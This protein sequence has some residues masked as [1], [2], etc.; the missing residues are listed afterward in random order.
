MNWSPISVKGFI[1]I[2]TFIVKLKNY[3]IVK[4]ELTW[5]IHE[6]RSLQRRGSGPRSCSE[7]PRV[8]YNE[9]FVVRSA[10]PEGKNV[11]YKNKGYEN[12]VVRLV[13]RKN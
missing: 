6:L 8:G 13:C 4:T 10:R 11:D 5:I 9:G 7:L 3:N 12:R 1:I 2:F